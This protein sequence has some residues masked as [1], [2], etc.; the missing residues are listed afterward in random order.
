MYKI[1][2]YALSIKRLYYTKVINKNP[3]CII[4]I[5]IIIIPNTYNISVSAS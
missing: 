1:P 3:Q 2:V 4:I 5:I